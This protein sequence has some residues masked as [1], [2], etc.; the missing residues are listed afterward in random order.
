MSDLETENAA[1]RSQL[2]TATAELKRLNLRYGW[3]KYNAFWNDARDFDRG[4]SWAVYVDS[5]ERYPTFDDAVD[6]AIKAHT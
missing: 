4:G 6:A 1:L 5:K 3:L 2:A